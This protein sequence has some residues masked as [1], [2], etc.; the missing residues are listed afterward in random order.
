MSARLPQW[1][2]CLLCNCTYSMKSNRFAHSL[3]P[4]QCS[5]FL[6]FSGVTSFYFTLF[7]FCLKHLIILE[8]GLNNVIYICPRNCQVLCSSFLCADSDSHWGH[9]LSA[10]DLSAYFW[11]SRSTGAELLHFLRLLL[12]LIFKASICWAL[13]SRYQ[14]FAVSV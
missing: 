14:D 13:V 7:Y 10:E 3:R 1:L 4:G 6:L 9:Y 2:H 8:R 12:D 11:L 5:V